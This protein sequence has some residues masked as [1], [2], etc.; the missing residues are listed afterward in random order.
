M[1]LVN[2]VFKPYDTACGS[3]DGMSETIA[4]ALRLSLYDP[5]KRAKLFEDLYPAILGREKTVGYYLSKTSREYCISF[6]VLMP[7]ITFCIDKFDEY[8]I[9]DE[10]CFGQ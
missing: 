5:T 9:H 4:S 2:Y 6:E 8:E 7:F 10:L 1:F 3:C